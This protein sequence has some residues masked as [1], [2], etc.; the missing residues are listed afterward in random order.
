MGH[1]SFVRHVADEGLPGWPL[2]AVHLAC[3]SVFAIAGSIDPGLGIWICKLVFPARLLEGPAGVDY[4]A[5]RM[6]LYAVASALSLVLILAVLLFGVREYQGHATN[7]LPR[8]RAML[9]GGGIG[10]L[11][12]L[13]YPML[14]LSNL[15]AMTNDLGYFILTAVVSSSL[16]LLMSA[17]SWRYGRPRKMETIRQVRL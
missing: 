1:K 7:R 6:S 9:L 3:L 15:P 2:V 10:G 14:A 13:G 12:W 5:Y 17:F 16:P 8:W 4:I 11:C